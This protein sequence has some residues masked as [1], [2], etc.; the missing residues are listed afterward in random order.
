M[1]KIIFAGIFAVAA[2]VAW[3]SSETNAMKDMHSHAHS[4]THDRM[5]GG[6]DKDDKNAAAASNKPMNDMSE[7][8]KD[9][10]KHTSDTSHAAAAA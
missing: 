1:T 6:K 9:A 3:N 10:P 4:H 7:K 5:D 2:M 8:M